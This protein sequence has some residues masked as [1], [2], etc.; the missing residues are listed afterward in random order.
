MAD[1]T[2]ELRCPICLDIFTDPVTLLCGHNFCWKCID[3]V[4]RKKVSG[5]FMCPQCRKR[6]RSRPVL[7]KNTN[8]S[9]IAERVRPAEHCSVI[10]NYC[11]FVTPATKTCLQCETSM[12][13][14]HLQ[15][16]NRS[17]QHDLI[18]CV[19][20]L[21]GH[22]CPIHNR[23]RAYYCPAQGTCICVSCCFSKE[24]R[25]LPV[26]PLNEACEKK[27]KRLKEIQ[28]VLRSKIEKNERQKE[29]IIRNI[30]KLQRNAEGA[31]TQGTLANK[32]QILEDFTNQLQELEENNEHRE[33]K[34]IHID[35][36]GYVTDPIDFLEELV[37]DTDDGQDTAGD[38]GT[39]QRPEITSRT[40]KWWFPTQ[41]PTDVSLDVDS[42][43]HGVHVSHNL[44]TVIDSEINLT[45]QPQTPDR[46]QPNQVLSTE[47]FDSGRH[48]WDV[49]T[50]ESGDWMIG[51]CYLSMD[52]TGKKSF[53]GCNSASWCLRRRNNEFWLQHNNVCLYL[54]HVTSCHT[55]RVSLDYTAGRLSFHDVGSLIS[56]LHTFRI[57]FTEPVHAAFTLFS[58]WLQ[59]RSPP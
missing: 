21:E 35:Y 23:M 43:G 33:T 49:E 29:N 47:E 13:K 27:K 55:V 50:S 46:F 17:V 8:L 32:E 4:L 2:D 54:P 59:I 38:T 5:S 6:F 28:E 58:G 52:R 48:Y 18:D 30:Q 41:K 10:C 37:I 42:A 12:C 39:V 25:G 22:K 40:K 7:T 1:L 20:T 57:I 53:L 31:L 24:Y 26:M 44:M 36:L 9:N 11:D 34:R 16:H 15:Y 14:R 45:K 19:S 3:Q 56:H 51:V